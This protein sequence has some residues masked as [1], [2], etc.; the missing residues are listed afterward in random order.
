MVDDGVVGVLV[1]GDVGVGIV[2]VGV[3]VFGCW[4]VW[5]LCLLVLRGTVVVVV[6]SGSFLCCDS[7]NPTRWFRETACH[8]N[9]VP[10]FRHNRYPRHPY[11]I[12]Q[13]EIRI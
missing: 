11:P 10:P 5:L 13:L 2:V 1:V 3:V 7:R 4:Y 6:G 8:N 9:E 12:F